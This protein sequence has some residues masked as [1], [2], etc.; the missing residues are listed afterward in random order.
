MDV[1]T[2][3]WGLVCFE[4]PITIA[5]PSSAE[6][7]AALVKDTSDRGLPVTVRGRGYS[8]EG[9]SLG[10][11]VVL[12]TERLTRVV[13]AAPD[14]ITVEAG[15]TWSALV[16]KGYHFPVL[17][18]WLPA[19]VGGTL[20][21]AGFSKGS[22]RYGF[23]IDHVVG[24]VV[25]T[26]DGRRVDCSPTQATWLFEAALGGFGEFGVI[27]EATLTL[28]ELPSHVR[29]VKRAVGDPR[30]L[31]AALEEAAAAEGTYH[32][33]SFASAGGFVVV[34]A[35]ASSR[36]DDEPILR[37]VAPPRPEAPPGPALWLNLFLPR[38]GLVPFLSSLRVDE[39]DAVQVI[40][41]A[42]M[43]AH[44]SS[45]FQSV[46]VEDSSLVHAVCVAREIRGRDALALTRENRRL[47]ELARSLGGKSYLAGTLPQGEAEWRA[48]L[49]SSYERVVQAKR[50][51]DP[52]GALG[53]LRFTSG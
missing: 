37:Y 27:V 11:G 12:S 23:Q 45:L 53:S 4:R 36:E 24:L 40:P 26:G 46:D 35:I 42:K 30:S 47:N 34:Q 2:R 49:G 50:A 18:G 19:T 9:Q 52:R 51:A 17:T 41:V 31:L 5:R 32:V 20:S 1:Y 28:A 14:R 8:V 15:V 38:E 22:H 25:V 13:S 29:I 7:V 3:D 16:E 48:H 33:T 21:T 39:G 44:T 10:R 6:E 43:R